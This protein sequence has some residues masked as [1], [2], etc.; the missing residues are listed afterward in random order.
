MTTKPTTAKNAGR[1]LA[2]LLAILFSSLSVVLAQTNNVTGG[3]GTS[4]T[5]N[6]Q[7]NP[8]FTFHRGVT[9]VFV[10]SGVSFHPFLG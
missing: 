8:A 6:G 2:I 1:R 10:L 4:Y 9:Y 7:P 3:N 5:I